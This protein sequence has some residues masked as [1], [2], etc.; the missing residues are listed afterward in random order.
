MIYVL[1]CLQI[2]DRERARGNYKVS[3]VRCSALVNEF[4]TSVPGSNEISKTMRFTPRRWLEEVFVEDP[5]NITEKEW[6]RIT[7]SDTVSQYHPRTEFVSLVP[8]QVLTHT[9]D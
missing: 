7:E 8:G 6:R 1:A 4:A 3:L 5:M 2:S 9:Q